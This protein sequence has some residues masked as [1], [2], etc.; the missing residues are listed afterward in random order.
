MFKKCKICG[1]VFEC[2]DKKKAGRGSRLR[3]KKPY[4][5]V[6][7]SKKCSK[8]NIDLCREERIKRLKDLKKN[9]K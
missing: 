5:A 3:S 8:A 2:Y 7:C 6:C 9:G 4:N 1:R